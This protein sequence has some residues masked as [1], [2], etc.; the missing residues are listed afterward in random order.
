M[1][2]EFQSDGNL[3]PGLHAASLREI[4]TRFGGNAA[5]SRQL[6]LLR[7]VVSASLVYPSIKRVLLWGSFVTSKAEPNDL[8]Y[9][10]V[11]SVFHKR[12][13]IRAEHSPF[14]L[15]GLARLRYGVDPNHLLI[16]D[17]DLERY[18]MRVDFIV[19]GRDEKHHGIV[20]IALRGE[21]IV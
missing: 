12:V 3:P 6:D 7:E 5:R 13:A 17:Y 9:S 2:P 10:L 1:I 15:P 16:E 14:L 21:Q 19:T 20:E 4:E 18:L 11:V 8:D